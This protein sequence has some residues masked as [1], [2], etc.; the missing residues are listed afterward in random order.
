MKKK[1]IITK[2]NR[3]SFPSGSM[4]AGLSGKRANIILG[5]SVLFA[6]LILIMPIS[7]ASAATVTLRPDAAGDLTLWDLGAGVSNYEAVD[8]ED[9]HDIDITYVHQSNTVNEDDLYNIGTDALL[10]GAPIN[11]V[12]VYAVAKS[13]KSGSGSVSAQPFYILVKSGGTIYNDAGRAPAIS[14]TLYSN[15]WDLDPNGDIA[16]TKAAIDDL[17]VGIRGSTGWWCGCK[18]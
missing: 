9:P 4:G 14:Y 18:A 15:T 10:T 2:Y 8:E 17:Q 11:S 3:N 1:K 5:Y 12:T 7:K 13:V 16:W 6:L